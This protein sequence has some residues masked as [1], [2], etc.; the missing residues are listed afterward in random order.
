MPYRVRE[1]VFISNEL[2]IL[3]PKMRFIALTFVI[4]RYKKDKKTNKIAAAVH[5]AHIMAIPG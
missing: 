3:V 1:T 5:H 2:F 4:I